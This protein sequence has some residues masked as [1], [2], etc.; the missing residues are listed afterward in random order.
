[1]DG[2]ASQLT[3]GLITYYHGIIRDK[4]RCVYE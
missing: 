4:E 3:S 1:M 2:K